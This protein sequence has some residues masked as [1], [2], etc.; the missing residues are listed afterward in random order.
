[1]DDNDHSFREILNKKGA[2]KLLQISTRTL[3]DWMRKKRIPFCKL[4]SGTVRFR[5]DQLIAFLAK[6]EVAA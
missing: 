1:M 6:H 2:S 3:D 5:R 4:P